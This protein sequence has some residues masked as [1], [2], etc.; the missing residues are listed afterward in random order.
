MPNIEY[1]FFRLFDE[2]NI[3]YIGSLA[4]NLKNYSFLIGYTVYCILSY[5]LLFILYKKFLKKQE[6]TEKQN[7]LRNTLFFLIVT[8]TINNINSILI[9]IFK[10]NNFKMDLDVQILLVGVV[11]APIF[12]E[13]VYRKFTVNFLKYKL[14]KNWVIFLSATIFSFSHKNIIQ[15]IPTFAAGFLLSSFFYKYNSIKFCIFLHILNNLLAALSQSTSNDV[16]LKIY[17]FLILTI[18]LTIYTNNFLIKKRGNI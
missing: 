14:S 18:I 17:F 8:Y 1:F 9:S 16:F 10:W 12:E 5:L 15:L 3:Y 13:L 7:Y 11:I 4:I 2:H 6:A